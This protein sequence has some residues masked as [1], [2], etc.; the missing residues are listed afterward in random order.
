VIEESHIHAINIL[1]SQKYILAAL[2]HS[3]AESVGA[4]SWVVYQL[5]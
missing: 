3:S 2:I 5:C 4:Q 1:L